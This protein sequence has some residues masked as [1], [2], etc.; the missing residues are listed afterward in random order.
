MASFLL[1]TSES[2]VLCME[3][4]TLWLFLLIC[5]ISS[6]FSA[7]FRST[8]PLTW[9]SSSWTRRILDSSCSRVPY[10]Y[11]KKSIKHSILHYQLL[12]LLRFP[13][14][15]LRSLLNLVFVPQPLPGQA[16][17][18]P[19]QFQQSAWPSPA[20]E[21]SFQSHQAAPSGQRSPLQQDI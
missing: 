6:S 15:S 10:L 19:S 5:S 8:S 4:V 1:L 21:C 17:S 11:I 14:E 13:I 7:S 12:N 3:S 16:G 2:R 9:F 18:Q 20:H